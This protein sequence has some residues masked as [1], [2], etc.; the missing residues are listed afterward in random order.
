MR[1]PISHENVASDTF[2]IQNRKTTILAT[3]RNNFFWRQ[4][5]ELF[6]NI[7]PRPISCVSASL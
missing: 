2:A 4:K 5:S 1:K 7:L 3:N 6:E